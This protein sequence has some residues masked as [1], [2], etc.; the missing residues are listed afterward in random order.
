MDQNL[1]EYRFNSHE[2]KVLR[3]IKRCRKVDD[4]YVKDHFSPGMMRA[5]VLMEADNGNDVPL[6]ISK[7]G[8]Y[9]RLTGPGE[10]LLRFLRDNFMALTLA[11]IISLTIGVF[12]L[13]LSAFHLAVD[14]MG[15]M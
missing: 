2:I 3:T 1:T 8:R 11:D 13:L 5:L 12:A 10:D 6:L 14:A 4:Q 15:L 7:K 9:Y